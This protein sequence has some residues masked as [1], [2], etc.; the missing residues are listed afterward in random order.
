M[1]GVRAAAGALE[2]MEC[3]MCEVQQRFELLKEVEC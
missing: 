2:G 3:E 1:V